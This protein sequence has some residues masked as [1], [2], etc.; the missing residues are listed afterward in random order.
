MSMEW[1]EWHE[2]AV[3]RLSIAHEEEGAIRMLRYLVQDLGITQHN[4]IDHLTKLEEAVGR[5]SAGEPL[6][7]VTGK[8]YFMDLTLVV[9]SG[10]LIPRSETEE[11]VYQAVQYV[12]S[13]SGGSLKILDIG[14]GSGCIALALKYYLPQC[15]VTAYDISLTA[16][17]IAKDNANRLQLEVNFECVDIL[18]PF[19]EDQPKKWDIIISNPPYIPRNEIHFMGKD[20]VDYEPSIALFTNDEDGLEFYQAIKAF[21]MYHLCSDGRIYL[22]INEFRSKAMHAIFCSPSWKAEILKDM[23]GK[24]RMM[25]VE[26]VI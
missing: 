4:F 21:A 12:K 13:K 17:E 2:R 11:L 7:Y 16:L 22:E 20:V 9:K 26:R 14:T 5:L 19:I 1:K 18:Q 3:E 10:V 25:V 6:A 8:A 24:D 23:Q 15:E